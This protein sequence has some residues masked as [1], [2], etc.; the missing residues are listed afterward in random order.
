MMNGVLLSAGMN[1]INISA[2]AEAEFNESMVD[3]YLS[4]DADNMLLFLL[5]TRK[6]EI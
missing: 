2:E 3:F 6:Y 4:R 5:E 1:A